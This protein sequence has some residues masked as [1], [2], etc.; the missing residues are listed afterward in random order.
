MLNASPSEVRVLFFSTLK[1]VVGTPELSVS[2]PHSADGNRLLDALEQQFPDLQAFRSYIRLA[3][4]EQYVENAHPLH[5]GD[6]VALITPV[7]GG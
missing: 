4:N 6:T 1:E 7:S 3:V 2:L 5:A